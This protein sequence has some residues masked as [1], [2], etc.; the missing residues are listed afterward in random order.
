MDSR[1]QDHWKKEN[2][3]KKKKRMQEGI[4]NPLETVFKRTLIC[5][6]NPGAEGLWTTKKKPTK[7]A[8]GRKT[9]ERREGFRKEVLVQG[10]KRNHSTC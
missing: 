7:E 3:R 6:S 5:G 2:Q 1:S 10:R 9:L 4:R 8:E